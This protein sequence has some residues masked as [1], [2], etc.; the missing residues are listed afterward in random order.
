MNQHLSPNRAAGVRSLPRLGFAGTGW[1]G[2]DRMRAL[3]EAG[4]AVPVAVADPDAGQVDAARALAPDLA[5][6]SDFTE[7]L[8]MDLDGI[9]IA[10]PSALHAGQSIAALRAGK[11]VFCQKPLG[12]SGDEVAAVV[13]AARQADRLLGLDLSYRHTSGMSAIRDL[14]RAGGLGKVF[15]AELVFHN[16]YGPDKPW[17][18]DCAQSGGGCLMD[19]GIHLA[20]LALWCFDFPEVEEVRA[21]IHAGGERTAD[22]SLAEDHAVADFTLEGGPNVRVACSWRLHAGQDAV[23]S[24]TFRGTKGGASFRNIGGSFYD[25]RAE[26]FAGTSRSLI[27]EGPEPWGGRAIVA[28]AERLAQGGGFNEDAAHFV[29]AARL[30][31]RIYTAA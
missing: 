17:F 21:S 2:L 30:L 14:I 11:A 16:A 28:W 23:I 7:L 27:S 31:D 3:V 18:Y 4:A 20:D 8:E 29:D 24:A 12:R 5:S 9:V 1:I 22:R 15:S 13:D 25:F 19:L 26:R 10:T 6:T